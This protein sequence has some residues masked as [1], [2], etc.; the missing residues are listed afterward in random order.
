M[1]NELVILNKYSIIERCINRINEIYD[2]DFN[3]LNDYNKQDAIVLNIQRACQAAIDIGMYIISSRKLGIPQSNK[4]TFTILEE[5]KI[6]TSEVAKN[7]RNMLRFRNIAIHEYQE[8]DLN[9][10]KDVIENH[11]NDLQNFAKEVLKQCVKGE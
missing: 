6:I 2:N 3:N 4:G 5:N 8:L 7:M 10:I 1:E 9:V 11:L